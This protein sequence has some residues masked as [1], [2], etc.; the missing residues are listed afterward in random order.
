MPDANSTRVDYDLGNSSF[1]RFPLQ[2]MVPADRVSTMVE[3]AYQ[4]GQAAALR[5]V[6][7][8][9]EDHGGVYVGV[10][11]REL[12]AVPARV[13]VDALERSRP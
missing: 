2:V 3:A 13:V 11:L 6:R 10:L 1:P 7:H 12:D 4:R 8:A 5:A 9:M